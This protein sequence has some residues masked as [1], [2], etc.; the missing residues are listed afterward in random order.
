MLFLQIPVYYPTSAPLLG[1]WIYRQIL[2]RKTAFLSEEVITL[3]G[4]YSTMR[5][6]SRNNLL[7]SLNHAAL[8]LLRPVGLQACD[9]VRHR[10][11]DQLIWRESKRPEKTKEKQRWMATTLIGM[12]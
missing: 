5:T 8:L 2:K 12:P 11:D 1:T 10:L 7:I 9:S 3:N 4:F 6:T